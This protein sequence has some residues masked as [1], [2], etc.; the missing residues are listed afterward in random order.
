MLPTRT[1]STSSDTRPL[2]SSRNVSKLRP[3]YTLRQ[4]CPGPKQ[5]VKKGALEEKLQYGILRHYAE[6]H[7]QLCFDPGK[8]SRGAN[9]TGGWVGPGATQQR[10]KDLCARQGSSMQLVTALRELPAYIR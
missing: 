9:Q 6:V 7:R 3:N 4:S 8:E 10:C 2:F 1:N 5:N